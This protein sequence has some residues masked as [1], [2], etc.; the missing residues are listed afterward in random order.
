MAVPLD[1]PADSSPSGAIGGGEEVSRGESGQYQVHVLPTVYYVASRAT[2]VLVRA[3]NEDIA[4]TIGQAAIRRMTEENVTHVRTVRPATPDDV[5]YGFVVQEMEAAT[6]PA[7]KMQDERAALDA[8]LNAMAQAEV[9][10]RHIDRESVLRGL[11]HVLRDEVREDVRR[12]V[13]RVLALLPS[14]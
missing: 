13:D 1:Q 2:S 8:L 12:F 4:R 11:V 10:P 14:R 6:L 5:A 3:T 7:R 9:H